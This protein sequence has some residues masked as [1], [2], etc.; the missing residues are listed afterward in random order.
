MVQRHRQRF[1]TYP[2]SSPA[3]SRASPRASRASSASYCKPG[4]TQPTEF[5]DRLLK[6]RFPARQYVFVETLAVMKINMHR[7]SLD[8]V[9]RPGIG[10]RRFTI[11]IKTIEM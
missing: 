8:Y 4:L 5:S 10:S 9:Y 11:V 7:S 1:D 6:R 2:A 3:S